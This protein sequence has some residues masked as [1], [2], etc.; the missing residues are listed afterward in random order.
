MTRRRVMLAAVVALGAC[1]E[2]EAPTPAAVPAKLR[3]APAAMPRLT[4]AQYDNTV[5]D[6]LGD[7]LALPATL[8]PDVAFEH[9]LT[10]GSAVAKVSPRGVELYEEAARSLA[11]QLAGKPERLAKLLPCKPTGPQDAVCLGQFVAHVG[12]RLWR[13]ALS[14]GEVAAVAATATKAA[15][16]LG[17]FDKAA[18]YAL[19]ALLQAPGFLYRTEHGEADPGHAGCKRLTATELASRLAY[20][21]WAG[22]PDAALLAAAADGSLHD[23]KVRAVQVERMLA[24]PKLRRSVRNWAGEWLQLHEV[25][26]LSKDPKVYKHF[27]GDLGAS[28]REETLRLVENLALDLDTDFRQFITTRTAFVDR[29][30]AAIYEVPAESDAG[31]APVQLPGWAERRGYLGQVS[32]LGHAAHPVSSS[33]TLRGAFV[34]RFL[35][36]DFVPD[37]PANLNTA[38]PEPSPDAKTLRQRLTAH[39]N[40]PGCSSCHKALDPIGF[41]F[42][43]FDGI[44]RFRTLDNGEPID[45]T[46]D[47]D[48]VPFGDLD[49]F[50]QVLA[51]SPKFRR[52]VTQ[53][54]YGYA[55][56]RPTV[57]GEKT[58]VDGLAAAFAANG[59]KVKALMREIA[60]SDGFARL[61]CTGG[62]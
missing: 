60:L 39:M 46:G 14:A 35:L 15:A 5:R 37:P 36:C 32:F 7:D 27:S 33:P 16:A 3:P 43:R 11:A 10:V 13:R 38:I 12:N 53:K 61:A 51:G 49:T 59:Y 57:A 6:V 8:E 25:V 26:K 40:V 44:G 34:R 24:D 22:P 4:R 54:L 41:A 20:F 42:E 9:L 28:A 55:V 23:P 56:A 47:L 48:G 21:L 50:A 62:P 17:S 31:H 18:E 1:G 58:Q 2:T 30:L 52:C 19:V 29:R 45:T